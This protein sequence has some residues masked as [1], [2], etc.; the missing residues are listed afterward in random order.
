MKPA[1]IRGALAALTAALPALLFPSAAAA[2]PAGDLRKDISLVKSFCSPFTQ[3]VTGLNGE[4]VQEGSGSVCVSKEKSSFR[5]ETKTPDE[6]LV[7]SD[8]KSVWSYDPFMQQVTIASFSEIAGSSPL[9]LIAS[10]SPEVW[11]KY[12][13]RHVK[14][15]YELSTADGGDRFEL[16]VSGGSIAGFSIV[17]RDGR[18]NSYRLGAAGPLAAGTDFSFEIPKGTE[19]DDRRGK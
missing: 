8:G 14:G 13:V 2:D 10:D 1:R 11:K 19:V 4:T 7:V 16:S 6:N 9:G 3:K 5:V 17:S 18:R 15:G 12:Q